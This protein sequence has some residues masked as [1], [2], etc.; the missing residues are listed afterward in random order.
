MISLQV[1]S[2]LITF[3]ASSNWGTENDPEQKYHNGNTDLRGFGMWAKLTN[4]ILEK[5]LKPDIIGYICNK[6]QLSVYAI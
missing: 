5:I 2:W 4:N 3:L 1:L 6:Y